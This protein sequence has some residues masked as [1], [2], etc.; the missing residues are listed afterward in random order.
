MQVSRFAAA[1]PLQHVTQA[2]E[3]SLDNDLLQAADA[4]Q[5]LKSAC[6]MATEGPMASSAADYACARE[7]AFPA[8]EDNAYRQLRMAD[9]SDSVAALPAEELQVRPI[10]HR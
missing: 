9:F 4:Q 8:A 6:K 1:F 2:T 3:P 10:L 5:W 7:Q